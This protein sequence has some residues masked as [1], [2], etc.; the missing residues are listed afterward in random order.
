MAPPGMLEAAI[1]RCSQLSDLNLPANQP[2]KIDFPLR[3]VLDTSSASKTASSGVLYDIASSIGQQ[4][5]SQVSRCQVTIRGG[6][7]LT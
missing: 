4:K 2:R 3:P 5:I 1:K 6:S 7:L